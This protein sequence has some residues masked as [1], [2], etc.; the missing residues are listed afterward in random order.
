[1]TRVGAENWILVVQKFI[2]LQRM[3]QLFASQNLLRSNRYLSHFELSVTV[4]TS[5]YLSSGDW[6]DCK[7]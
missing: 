2:K 6:K 7:S 3:K 5:V 1:M 4:S